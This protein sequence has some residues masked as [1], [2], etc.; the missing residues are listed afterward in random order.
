M[1]LLCFFFFKQKTAYEVRIS[2]WSSDVCSS[3]LDVAEL[4]VE[5]RARGKL[6]VHPAVLG[7]HAVDGHQRGPQ[8]LLEADVGF[9]TGHVVAVAAHGVLQRRCQQGFTGLEV[10]E[11]GAAADPRSGGDV[12]DPHGE[13]ALGQLA[14]RSEEHTSELQ[15]LM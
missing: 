2:D 5:V 9:R 7:V 14:P 1:L 8:P 12:L 4:A 10:P 6:E 13:T 15:S 11:H 3:D